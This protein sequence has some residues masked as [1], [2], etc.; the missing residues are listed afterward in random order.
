MLIYIG[1][2]AHLPQNSEKY[3]SVTTEYVLF[4]FS[5]KIKYDFTACEK[6]VSN[7]IR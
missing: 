5:L 7:T 2:R 4:K 1:A 6:H 3:I